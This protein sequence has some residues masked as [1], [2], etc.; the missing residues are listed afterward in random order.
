MAP[1]RRLASDLVRGA[2]API[3]AVLLVCLTLAPPAALAAKKRT[4]P[5]TGT[6]GAAT[7]APEMIRSLAWRPIGPANQG[8]RVSEITFVP[9]KPSQFFVATGTGGLFKT[10]N[11][12]T[13][14]SPVFDEQ[15]VLSIGSVAVA[16]SDPTIVYVGTGEGNG[17]NSSTWGNGVYKSTDGG[18]SF[19]PLGLPDS[20]DIPRLAVHPKN[21]DVVY[22]AVMGHLWD[23]NR[24]RG[25]YKTADGGKTWQPAFQ[26][27]E[28]TGCI[29]VL[30]DPRNP[31]VVYAAMYARRRKPW[32]FESGGFGDKG[33]LYKSTD[34]GRSFKRLTA[35]LPGKTGRI[36]LALFAGDPA[37]VYAVIE[38]DQ[39]G[40]VGLQENLSKAGGVFRSTD[41]GEHWTRLN[42][43][44][45]RSFY[46]SK[47]VVD[48]KDEK[49]LYVL[50]FGLA[51]S[52]DGGATFRA[53][54]AN[55]PHPDKHTL[56]VDPED[57]D[58]VL[59]GTDGGVY[60]SRDR[61]ATWRYL[62]NLATGEFY[63]IGLGMD[64]PYTVC[65]G[66][67][68]NGTWC[69]P[70]RGWTI[71]GESEEKA[72]NL[73]NLDWL[74]VW[75]GDGYYAAI[76][77]R[78]PLIIYAEAQ[79]GYAARIDFHTHR[80]T[81]IRPREKEGQAGFR[82][83]WNSPL[84]LSRH[85]PDVLYL[86]GNSLFKLARRG[87]S[88]ERISPDLS[89]RDVEKI[90]TV[91][92]GAENYGTIV[93]LAESPLKPGVLW[94]GTDDGNV[95]LTRDDGKTWENLTGRL[96]GVPKG[97]YVSRLEA[98]HFEAGTAYAAFDGHRTGDNRVYLL[99]TRDAGASWRSIASD[100]PGD[101]PVRVVREDPANPNLLFAGTEFG[102]FASFDRGGHW[103]SLRGDSLPA[104]QVHDLQIHPRDRDLV[105]GTHG[106]SVFILDDITGLEQMTAE[107]LAKPLVLLTPRPAYGFHLLERGGLWGQNFFGAK[108]PPLATF[109]YLVKE[110]DPEGAKL[111]IKDGSGGV[112]RE[113]KG[114]A[115]PGL[116][117]IGWDLTRDKEQVIPTLESRLPGQSP[118]V[119][120]GE[121]DLTLTVG[122][123]KAT[124]K[125]TVHNPDE[126]QTRAAP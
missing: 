35:G 18:D 101:A 99:E 105:A 6:K 118:F 69:G 116:E 80:I 96:A 36:G 2:A 68:D 94:A 37:H 59:L 76:D 49:R 75:D 124:G 66:L 109:N 26:I 48:P 98:S 4:P 120:S 51:I 106:R 10:K 95:Q 91:G 34:G 40:T 122:K 93:T 89:G 111:V 110:R 64:R 108:N 22:A 84:I 8:G 5:E 47:I 15:P 112:V 12:G 41:S 85:D 102:V 90:V 70:S 92:S 83:N 125:I 97:T 57:T 24:E 7:V 21:P 27:D 3:F 103:I 104:V 121:Y 72:M 11:A 79:E 65:G 14:F 82:F 38:S 54:G 45:P 71:F 44:T 1:F 119:P 19:V 32:S 86:G 23:A 117:R 43:L 28:N 55:L 29:D 53:N 17:R 73:S 61:A 81:D 60:E 115:E 67:Q 87:D 30:L 113:L 77:P 58:H 100:L 46:F 39:A 31:E 114:P 123:E 13:T 20:R 78:D 62:D 126:P 16:P 63:E 107:N 25:L 33:G 42:P 56:V 52:D 50:G 9:G 88:W 74:T